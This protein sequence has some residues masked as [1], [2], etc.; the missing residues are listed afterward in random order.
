MQGF[1][2][3]QNPSN[4]K[5]SEHE[6]EKRKFII[7]RSCDCRKGSHAQSRRRHR[8]LPDARASEEGKVVWLSGMKATGMR[9]WPETRVSQNPKGSANPGH[10]NRSSRDA[11]L[12]KELEEDA[13]LEA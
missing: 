2:P 12:L 13:A 7:G 10:R 9:R 3:D 4:P 8:A 5:P 11:V 1:L 6:P